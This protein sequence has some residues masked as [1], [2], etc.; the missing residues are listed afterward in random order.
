MKLQVWN[1]INFNRTDCYNVKTVEEGILLID[2]LAYA[3]LKNKEITDNTFDLLVLNEESQEWEKWYDETGLG[4]EDFD[5]KDGKVVLL[6][7]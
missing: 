6:D 2:T 4:V 7:E 1:M 5:V 3:Q